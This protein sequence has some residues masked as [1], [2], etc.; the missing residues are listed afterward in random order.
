MRLEVRVL[1]P[2]ILCK[3]SEVEK[4][5]EMILHTVL[6]ITRNLLRVFRGFCQLD[7][8]LPMRQTPS[9][10]ENQVNK[11]ITSSVRLKS[12]LLQKMVKN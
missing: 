3:L 9:K 5:M 2:K 6:T 8:H 11:N 4:T 7:G 12:N 1:S 10:F